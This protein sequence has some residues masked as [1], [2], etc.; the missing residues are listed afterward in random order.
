MAPEL[1]V[2]DTDGVRL[3]TM[4]RP[5]VRNAVD[6]RLAGQL[7]DAL[8]GL[9]SRSDLLVGVLCGAGGTFSSGMDLRAFATD[10]VPAVPGRGFAGITEYSAAKP[11]VA[12]VEG[13]AL[14]GG[15]EIALACDVIV[16]ART[17]V[18]GLP[19]VRWGLVAAAGGL[20]RLPARLPYHVAL[21]HILTG[22]PFD[23][24]CAARYGLVSRLVDEGRA[25][26][27][28]LRIATAIAANS[29]IAVR[30]SKRVVAEAAGWPTAE[31]F[32][33][34]RRL[35]AAVFDSPDAREGAAA[36]TAKRPPRWRTA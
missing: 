31:L 6:R 27:E 21:L 2:R 29:P 10:G 35:T 18:F 14:A 15:L 33:R 20:L 16:A 22:E 26:A 36:F 32:D 12:A 24:G 34:Q 23:A 9:D 25:V 5:D 8:I 28:A 1:L 30:T 7:A 17:A 3:M 13:H 19:E 11:L 4:N